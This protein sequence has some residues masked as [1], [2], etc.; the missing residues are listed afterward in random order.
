MAQTVSMPF[1]SKFEVHFHSLLRRGLELRRAAC[2]DA[3]GRGGER[4]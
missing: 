3:P 1:E 4:T 2:K